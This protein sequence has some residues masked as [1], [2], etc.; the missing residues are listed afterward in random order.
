M[1][2]PNPEQRLIELVLTHPSVASQ[3]HA[4]PQSV[5]MPFAKEHNRKYL[6]VSLLLCDTPTLEELARLSRTVVS[7][8]SDNGLLSNIHGF[9]VV[10]GF[11]K[12]GKPQRALRLSALSS[13]LPYMENV[14]AT[15]LQAPQPHEGMTSI[16]YVSD[17]A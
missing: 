15:E 8:A 10:F 12:S 7:I 14:T 4:P 17:L 16:L 11:I 2:V 9:E 6:M 13:A 1:S 3:L 5:V